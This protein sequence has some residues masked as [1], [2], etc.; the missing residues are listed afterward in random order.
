MSRAL[1]R[2][3]VYPDPQRGVTYYFRLPRC[4]PGA[5][6]SCIFIRRSCS[7]FCSSPSRASR[8]HRFLFESSFFSFSVFLS[9]LRRS[10]EDRRND[11]LM[12]NA[13]PKEERLLSLT[14]W[15]SSPA[16]PSCTFLQHPPPPSRLLISRHSSCIRYPAF[17]GKGILLVF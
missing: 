1:S 11:P 10:S 3:G 15:T 8:A 14:T 4:V 7:S 2:T 9:L 12:E 13:T 16:I 5:P 6:S 17:F